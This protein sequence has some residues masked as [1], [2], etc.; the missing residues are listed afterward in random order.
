MRVLLASLLLTVPGVAIPAAPAGSALVIVIDGVRTATGRVH[1]EVCTRAT[2]LKQCAW[3]GEVAAHAGTVTVAVP[4]VP[5][6]TYAIQAYHDANG[7]GKLDRNWL[8][9]PRE[10]VAFSR[11]ARLP[12][13]AP[14]FAETAFEHGATE[15]RVALKLSRY[16]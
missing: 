11:L 16:F 9:V 1:A 12:F 10:D 2:F 5:P 15:Q 7:N 14:T 13:R 3:I 8:G 4:G 6:G